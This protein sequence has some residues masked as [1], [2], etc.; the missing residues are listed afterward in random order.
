MIPFN[1]LAHPH[2]TAAN[3]ISAHPEDRPNEPLAATVGSM[4]VVRRWG[5]T[6]T[7]AI[8][9]GSG[10]GATLHIHACAF[11]EL[12]AQLPALP[13]VSMTAHYVTGRAE[14]EIVEQFT[15]VPPVAAL[16]CLGNLV[17]V[18]AQLAALTARLQAEQIRRS[19]G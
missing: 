6:V 10:P 12:A 8:G 2:R 19:Q 9:A 16:A 15:T 5:V 18:R 4:T 13:G 1:A 7:T 3:P 11:S 17:A 14:V